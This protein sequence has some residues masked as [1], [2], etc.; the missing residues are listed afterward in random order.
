MLVPFLLI[1][2]GWSCSSRIG[3]SSHHHHHHDQQE[4]KRHQPDGDDEKRRWGKV[5]VSDQV[6]E[7]RQFIISLLLVK[8]FFYSFCSLKTDDW[9]T[10]DDEIIHCSRWWSYWRWESHFVIFKFFGCCLT[11]K[12]IL[13]Q[14]WEQVWPSPVSDLRR[15]LR[16]KNH[17]QIFQISRRDLLEWLIISFEMVKNNKKRWGGG[18]KRK[19]SSLKSSFG[20]S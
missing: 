20:G 17:F 16:Q 11:N 18:D 9:L 3:I 10:G 5:M 1:I 13:H 4:E 8:W 7:S 14:L 19:D 15:M 12:N 6:K 2:H